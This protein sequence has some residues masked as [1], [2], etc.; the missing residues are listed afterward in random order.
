MLETLERVI[1]ATACNTFIK[2]KHKINQCTK[3]ST[4]SSDN[5][6]NKDVDQDEPIVQMYFQCDKCETTHKIHRR[7]SH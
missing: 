7:T 4:D 6:K 5:T 3:K 1:S 2:N